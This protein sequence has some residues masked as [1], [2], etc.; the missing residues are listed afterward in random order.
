MA[1]FNGFSHIFFELDDFSPWRVYEFAQTSWSLPR[2]ISHHIT[3]IKSWRQ[4]CAVRLIIMTD[5]STTDDT[6]R[7]EI[8]TCH[9]N[10]MDE[11]NIQSLSRCS[12]LW[13]IILWLFIFFIYS[14][15]SAHLG[16]YLSITP[17]FHGYFIFM[18]IFCE[19]G[20]YPSS[21]YLLPLTPWPTK[22]RAAQWHSKAY[23]LAGIS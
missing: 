11:L 19:I 7:T 1:Y 13:H 15:H 4:G 17:T 21:S 12:F 23:T 20:L 5:A 2:G 14:S 22:L 8:W 10:P 16:V 9:V 18:T 6:H 3:Y